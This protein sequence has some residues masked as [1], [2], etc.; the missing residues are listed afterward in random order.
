MSTT[1]HGEQLLPPKDPSDI[2]DYALAFDG[3][4][5][6]SGEAITGT[7][8]VVVD[9][10]GGDASPIVVGAIALSGTPA[11]TVNVF[12]SAGSAGN[13]YVV[14]VT[15]VTTGSRTFQRTFRLPV[16]DL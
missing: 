13:V 8:S 3:D 7:P 11:R 14:R 1:T 5:F 12:F 9:A 15:F 6:A 2:V 16:V 10:I 4:G